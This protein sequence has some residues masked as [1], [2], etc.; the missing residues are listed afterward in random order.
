MPL[1][2][3][4]LKALVAALCYC[5]VTEGGPVNFLERHPCYRC[6]PSNSKAI[7]YS[8]SDGE[9]HESALLE[10]FGWRILVW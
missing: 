8:V 9:D 3:A 4:C 10:H 1:M 5:R 2:I 7:C 6:V